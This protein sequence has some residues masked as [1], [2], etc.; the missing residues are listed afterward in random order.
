MTGDKYIGAVIEGRYK[1]EHLLGQGGMGAV[2]AGRHIMVGKQVAI[3]FLHAEFVGKEEVVKRFYRE[4]QA[5]A[6][7]GHKNIIDVLDVGVF[8]GKEPYLVM[9]YLEGES[10]SSMLERTGSIDL[11]AACGIMDPALRALS[12]AHAKGIIHRDLKPDNIFLVQNEG[13]AP[14][15]KLIDFG[16]SKFTRTSGMS[17]LTQ[18]GSMLGTPAYMSPE[19]ARG[20]KNI[21]ERSDIYAMGVILYQMLTGKM[22]FTGDH[23][24]Q[25]LINVLTSPPTPPKEAYPGFPDE[26]EQLVLSTLSK[27]ADERPSSALDLLESL[28]KTS[29]FANRQDR[30]THFA[31]GIKHTSFAGGDLGE[32][33]D[34]TGD[35]KV[36]SDLLAQMSADGETPGQWQGTD[37]KKTTDASK[38]GLFIGIGGALIGL[39]AVILSISLLVLSGNSSKD[40]PVITVPVSP[41]LPPRLTPSPPKK[42]TPAP[43][44]ENEQGVQIT[45]DNVPTGAKILYRD[46]QVPMNPFR[47]DKKNTI[48]K[49]RV[50]AKGFEPFLISVIPNK[51]LTV[52]AE[53]EPIKVKVTKHHKAKTS[54]S[55]KPTTVKKSRPPKSNVKINKKKDRF[56][57]GKRGIKFGDAFD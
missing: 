54:P 53:L 10:L 24:N 44:F 18:T 14:I 46:T 35:S 34:D 7:I 1:I 48:S 17:Q 38:K 13:D 45:I 6:A 22:P 12:A 28:K 33:R 40:K 55:P 56:K 36:A 5:A 3:K 4:A 23:Y 41:A 47:V 26:A 31:T 57:S 19:Q 37:V 8:E 21:D 25:L 43:T 32:S 39:V 16:I 50:E 51:D 9:E 49:L 30:L 2:Y 11:A 15:V 42:T 52:R 27:V 29:E 20:D